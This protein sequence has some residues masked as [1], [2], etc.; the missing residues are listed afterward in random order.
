MTKDSVFNN[1]NSYF[2][3]W[4]KVSRNFNKF[5]N[6]KIGKLNI[7]P[8][9]IMFLSKIYYNEGISQKG[10]AKLLDVSNANVTKTFKKLK[11]KGYVEKIIDP[12]NNTRRQLYLTPNGVT[13]FEK[14]IDIYDEFQQII[15]DEYGEEQI[16]EACLLLEKIGSYA[17][18]Y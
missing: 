10:V 8:T 18:N 1:K 11:N 7:S 14:I 17:L 9:E 6:K 16:K 13:V 2:N 4:Y 15:F 3:E 5:F 12:N